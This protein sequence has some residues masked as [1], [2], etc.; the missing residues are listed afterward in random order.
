MLWFEVG[1][2]ETVNP[3]VLII[4]FELLWPNQI[5]PLIPSIAVKTAAINIFL[6]II[7]YYVCQY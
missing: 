3:G 2:T 4:L 6:F 5:K 7:Y 1:D